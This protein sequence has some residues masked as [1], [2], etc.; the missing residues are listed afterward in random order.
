M[1]N[2]YELTKRR[3]ISNRLYEIWNNTNNKQR[4]SYVQGVSFPKNSG[5]QKRDIRVLDLGTDVYP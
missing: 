4:R 2:R 5:N 1:G 3:T